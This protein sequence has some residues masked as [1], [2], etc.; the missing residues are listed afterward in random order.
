MSKTSKEKNS[1]NL[2]PQTKQKLD[3][4]NKIFDVWLTVWN[5]P[6]AQQWIDNTWYIIDLFAGPGYYNDNGNETL[7]SP[8]VCLN[9]INKYRTKLIANNIKIKIFLVE[10]DKK[11][12]KQLEKKVDRFLKD[13]PDLYKIVDTKKYPGDCNVITK[14]IIK[15][16][17]NNRKK[18]IFLFID[19]FG[20]NIARE[21]VDD[22]L[23]LQ[24]PIDGIVN[25][26]EEGV[27][28]TKGIAERGIQSP[29]DIKTVKTL[30]QFLGK[31][32]D[33]IKKKGRALLEEYIEKLWKPRKYSVTGLSMKYANRDD[34]LYYL[35]FF[36]KNKNIVR[37]IR[38]IY[39]SHKQKINP[40]LFGVESYL[41]SILEIDANNNN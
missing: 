39:A 16:I 37:I 35:L 17:E 34:I 2:K 29:G 30:T 14:D 41:D 40:S 23:N 27:R 31:D 6:K 3:L 4:F 13:T 22:L 12:F 10:E 9:T 19:P 28:R 26:S 18:P 38:N 24:N 15:S 1:Q 25:Y 5:G 21:T 20:I 8:L 11:V 36:S 32:V 7:G 33:Y